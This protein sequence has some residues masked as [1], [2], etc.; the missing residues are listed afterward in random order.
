MNDLNIKISAGSIIKAVLILVLFYFLYILRDLVLII[1]TAVVIA[2]AVEPATQWLGKYKISRL[3]AVIIIY[4]LV[5]SVLSGILYIFLPPLLSQASNLLS[6]LPQYID[7]INLKDAGIDVGILESG[8]AGAQNITGMMSLN[9]ILNNLRQLAS[10]IS[11]NVFQTMSTIFGGIT[12]F[13]LIVI[14]SFYLAVQEKGIDNF[15]RILTPVQHEERVIG[16]W[17]RAQRKIGRWMQGQLLLVVVIGVL[18]YLGLMLVG[19]PHALFLAVIAGLLELIP[20]FGPIIAAVPAGVV[21]LLEG[22]VPLALIVV[23]LYI[24]IQQFENHLI[25]PLVVKKVVGV[26]ALVVIVALIAGAKLAGFLGIILSVPAAAIIQELTT[27]VQ[28]SKRMKFNKEQKKKK[29]KA[30]ELSEE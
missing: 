4:V 9:E 7:T 27:D 11:N 16:I 6:L 22:G 29:E 23:G 14:F 1:L 19:V 15:L 13:I 30:T 24:I 3:P 25:Y 10:S 8:G 26:P 18:V 12:S 17:R 21:A 20:L 2:S 5:V 28:Q